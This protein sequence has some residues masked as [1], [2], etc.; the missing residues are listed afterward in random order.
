M[1]RASVSSVSMYRRPG[2]LALAIAL[3][4]SAAGAGAGA[5][6]ALAQQAQ[7][8]QQEAAPSDEAAAV[9]AKELDAVVV[10]G[11]RIRREPGFEGPAPVTSISA[12]RIRTSGYTQI[13]DLMNQ[14]PSFAVS[15]SDQTSNNPD[16]GNVGINALDLRGMGVQRTLTLVDGHR[17]VPS[18]PGTSGVD[19]SMLPASMIQR[20]EV[21]TG[22]ASA[23]YGADAVNGVVNFILR[24]DFEGLEASVRYGDSSR[25]DMPSYS[26]DVLFG[27]N[28]ADNRGNFTLYGFWEKDNGE[29][30]GQDRPWTANG[31]PLY[32]R[33][34]GAGKYVVTEGNRNFYDSPNANIVIG[35]CTP[36]NWLDCLYTF[37]ANGRLRRPDLGPGGLVNMSTSQLTTPESVLQQGRTNGGEY[38]GRYDNWF[39]V[40]PSDRQSVRSTVNFDFNDAARFFANLTYSQSQS[41][42]TGRALATYGSGGAESVPY[43]SPFITQEMIDANGGPFTQNISFARNFDEDVGRTR[44][45]YE[46]KLLQMVTGLEGDFDFISRAWNYSAYVSY[47]RSSERTRSRNAASYDRLLEGLNS[48]VDGAGNPVCDGSWVWNG[49]AYDWA[50]PTAG[51]VAIN[52]FARLTPGMVGWLTYDTDWS[53]TTMTQKV[54]SAYVSGG[55]FDLPGGEAQ[56]VV[57]A[58]YRKESNDIGVIPQFNPDDPRYDP[59][60]GTTATPL[61][62]EYSVKEAFGE[63]HLPLLDGVAGAERLSLDLAGRLSDYN[64]A[65]R[66]ATSKIGL[67]WAPIHDVTLRG[68]WGKAIRAPNIGEMFTANSVS[69]LWVYDP[70]NDYSVQYRADR[71]EY[72]AAN[73]AA[74]NPSDTATYWQWRDIVYSGNTGLKPETAKTT[75]FGVVLRPRF[76]DNLTVSADY[77]RIDLR[78]V[79]A[80]LAPQMILNRCVDQASLDNPFCDLVTRNATGDLVEVA[81]QQMNLSQSIARGVDINASWFH[82]LARGGRV[83]VDLSAGRALERTD[84]ADPQSPDDAW[85][86]VG[87]FGT[88][89]WKGSLRTGWSNSTFSAYWT[90]RGV[91]KMRAGRTI[92][93]ETY[94][95]PWAGSTFYNDVYASYQFSPK[96]GVY[97][98]MSNV[99][100]RAP[101]R[102][103]GAEAGGANFNQ[104]ISGYQAGLYDVIGRTFY[105]GFRVSM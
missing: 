49:S 63:L 65:G 92:T 35:G 9:D 94:D 45:D 14:L 32:E 24:K 86:Y 99:F 69:G 31:H 16:V 89:K 96:A 83:S 56:L 103:P 58:E 88:P 11:S 74:I 33:P 39:L 79:I 84:I 43:T 23:L 77:Y 17:Q 52:P 41:H 67:E 60:L 2:P 44:T 37:D 101:P 27:R 6:H 66:T 80:G 81:V 21:V 55:L 10:T 91:S 18:I 71:S 85:D 19:V 25:G 102:I 3:A 4:L 78:G 15:Q 29:V 73:C 95:R 61:V 38:G 46:R 22:G 51:C 87:L 13:A 75:T 28:F 64:L 12:E 98:G 48:T 47:G 59:S 54:A 1:S 100:D 57:G 26:A 5:P 93:E 82:D 68:T 20:V 104:A 42:S 72:T 36:A 50:A 105:V 62:G 34:G 53:D 70:C 40:V 30:S 90:L 8:P 97:A 7:A 76:V